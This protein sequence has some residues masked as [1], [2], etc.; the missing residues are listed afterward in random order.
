[1]TTLNDEKTASNGK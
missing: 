1:M